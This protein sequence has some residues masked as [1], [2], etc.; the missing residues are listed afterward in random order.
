M[1]PNGRNLT[2]FTG[3]TEIAI[4]YKMIITRIKF[5]GNLKTSTMVS[6]NVHRRLT[7]NTPSLISSLYFL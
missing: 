3:A 2:N 4:N 5:L 6:V 1:S 7:E